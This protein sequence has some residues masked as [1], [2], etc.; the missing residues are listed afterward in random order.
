MIALDLLFG[1]APRS[2]GGGLLAIGAMVG[3][4]GGYLYFTSY[5]RGLAHE[6]RQAAR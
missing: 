4:G 2:V 1:V 3:F 5:F 6:E